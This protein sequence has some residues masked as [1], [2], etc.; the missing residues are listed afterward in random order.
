MSEADTQKAILDYLAAR[1]IMAF[2]MNVGTQI[3]PAQG[4]FK[5]RAIHSGVLGMADILAFRVRKTNYLE[6]PAIEGDYAK[7]IIIPLWIEVKSLT[8]KQS[9][10]QKDFQAQVEAEGHRYTVARSIEDVE[11]ALR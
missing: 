1:R 7:E 8:G 2:R 9:Q 5:R 6:N 11:E 10:A 3:I 4:G